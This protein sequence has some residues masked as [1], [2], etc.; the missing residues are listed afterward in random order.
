MTP[1]PKPCPFSV[2]AEYHPNGTP[3]NMQAILFNQGKRQV[4]ARRCM[5]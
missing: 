5:A 1:Y 2:G 3:A 4:C